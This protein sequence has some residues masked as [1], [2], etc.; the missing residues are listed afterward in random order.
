MSQRVTERAIRDLLGRGDGE[1]EARRR[2]V[3]WLCEV[4]CG[5]A[6]HCYQLAVRDKE[7]V[8]SDV[9][10]AGNTE[11]GER[12]KSLAGTPFGRQV[13]NPALP[14]GEVHRF[15]IHRCRTT[16]SRLAEPICEAIAPACVAR[17]PIYHGE[18][19]IAVAGVVR[20]GPSARFSRA[21]KRLL[22]GIVEPFE[23]AVVSTRTRPLPAAPFFL[24]TPDGLLHAADRVAE[25]WLS[26]DR[27]AFVA[28]WIAEA[29]RREIDIDV[30]FLE[31]W[32]VELRRLEGD[33][34][35]VYY[36]RVDEPL[37]PK[38]S[39]LHALTP[40]QRVVAR[41]AAAGLTNREV[42]EKLEMSAE[43]VKTH[44]KVVYRELFVSNRIELARVVSE[45]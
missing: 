28:D 7:L 41:E 34:A 37:R 42:A 1:R 25:P 20:C 15:T 31:G 36:V 44:L 38:L 22:A 10:V 35:D 6:A 16:K 14:D 8:Y 43:T 12:L 32:S 21:D 13:W 5:D 29:E 9:L 3:E 30:R 33:G 40:T 45:E 26:P 39:P 18:E 23:D 11:V 2:L 4:A 19:L 17:L 27:R 24:F